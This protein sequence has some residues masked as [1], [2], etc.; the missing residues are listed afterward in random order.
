MQTEIFKIVFIFVGILMLCSPHF[1]STES[2]AQGKELS[3][4]VKA[5]E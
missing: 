4:R 2:L 5:N 1:Y 3:E